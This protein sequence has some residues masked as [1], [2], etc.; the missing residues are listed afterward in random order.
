GT[1]LFPQRGDTA[2][3][4]RVSDAGGQPIRVT[5]VAPSEDNHFWPRFL[6]DGRRFLYLANRAP[7]SDLPRELRLASLESKESRV[8]AR[9]DSRA[10]FV[11]PGYL[12]YVRE[13]TLMAQPF[14]QRSGRLHGEPS[15]IVDGVYYF[16]GTGNAGFSCSQNGIVAF[17]MAYTGST[18]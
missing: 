2:G 15:P 11:A 13:G 4:C 7:A 12:I 10:E 17:T 8:V 9:L 18:I 6:P 1:I 14:D 3:L 5:T 16:M